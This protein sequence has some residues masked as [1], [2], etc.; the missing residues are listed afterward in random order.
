MEIDLKE[1]MEESG[2]EFTKFKLII[3]FDDIN[4]KLNIKIPTD[5]KNAEEFYLDDILEGL[6][7]DGDGSYNED[8]ETADNEVK[9]YGFTVKYNVPEDLEMSEYSYDSFKMYSGVDVNVDVSIDWYTIDE[10]YETLVDIHDSYS[11]DDYETS[12]SEA[13][14]LT[15]DGKEITCW[16]HAYSYGNERT[17]YSVYAAYALNDDYTFNAEFRSYDEPVSEE[18]IESFMELDVTEEN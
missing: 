7:P 14:T 9:Q 13:K 8:L 16:T 6:V 17:Y 3:T 15:V 1:L 4:K 18:Y 2:N 11:S 12:L 10:Y 5:A